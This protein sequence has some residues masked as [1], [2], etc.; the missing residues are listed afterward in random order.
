MT[1]PPDMSRRLEHWVHYSLLVGLVLSGTLLAGGLAVDWFSP[2]PARPLQPRTLLETVS[3]ALGGNA[4]A[5][6][7]LGILALMA[8]PLVR[9]IILAIGWM[10]ER[11]WRMAAVATT[12]FALLAASLMLGLG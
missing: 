8:T 11:Q 1:S 5:L 4:R 7:N 6:M 3:G 9:V 2:E 10:T 12:V